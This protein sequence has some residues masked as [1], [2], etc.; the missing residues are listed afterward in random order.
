MKT[1]GVLLQGG[2]SLEKGGTPNKRTFF[3]SNFVLLRTRNISV[4]NLLK[5]VLGS[6]NRKLVYTSYSIFTAVLFTGTGFA[7]TI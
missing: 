5:F 2:F 6:L 1:N 3:Y 4:T 7:L